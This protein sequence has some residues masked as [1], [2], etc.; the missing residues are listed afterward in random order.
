MLSPTDVLRN[1]AGLIEKNGH[2]KKTYQ[3]DYSLCV[4]GAIRFAVCGSAYETNISKKEMDLVDESVR[5]LASKLRYDKF[6]YFPSGA[7]VSWND[8]FWRTKSQVV[9]T[10]RKSSN[11]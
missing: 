1:A 10:L 11:A 4:V 2:T 8:S 9:N 6:R 5:L 3:T 7:V